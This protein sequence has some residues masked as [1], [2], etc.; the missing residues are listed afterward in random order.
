MIEDTDCKIEEIRDE[1]GEKVAI[2]IS[3]CTFNQN[4]K[5]Y[6]ERWRNLISNI[7]R[8]GRDV[9][10]ENLP[11]YMLIL[12]EEKKREV[13]WKHTFFIDKCKNDLKNLPLFNDYEKMVKSYR[14]AK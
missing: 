14:S 7:K 10:I 8:V 13:M 1:F 9:L 11:Y 6:K 4:I 12:N 5:D 2:L 3:A